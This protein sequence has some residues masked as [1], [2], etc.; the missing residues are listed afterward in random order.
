MFI[1]ITSPEL[2]KSIQSRAGVIYGSGRG[3]TELA[4]GRGTVQELLDRNPAG[5]DAPKPGTEKR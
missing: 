2:A 3:G 1:C 5:K 4:A